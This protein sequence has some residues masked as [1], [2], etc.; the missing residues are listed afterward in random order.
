M[1]TREE[2]ERAAETVT[3][4]YHSHVGSG[5]YLSDMDLEYAR[6]AL[7]PFPEA[8]QIVVALPGPDASHLAAPLEGGC[9][10]GL[11]IFVWDAT[12]GGF[13]G[14]RIRPSTP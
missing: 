2:A 4:I 7:F 14:R 3:A 12:A 10:H 13:R 9:V 11:G 1:R 8:D 5:A 6:H